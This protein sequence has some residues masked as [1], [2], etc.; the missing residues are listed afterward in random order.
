MGLKEKTKGRYNFRDTQFTQRGW[1][2]LRMSLDVLDL[3]RV[4]NVLLR[5]HRALKK[6]ALCLG[7]S[8]R[9]ALKRLSSISG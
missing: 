1:S 8:R 6:S 7:T 9:L 3:V 2:A 5:Q 4:T